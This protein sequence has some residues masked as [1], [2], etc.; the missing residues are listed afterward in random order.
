L[1]RSPDFSAD[2]RAQMQAA[3][4]SGADSMPSRAQTGTPESADAAGVSAEPSLLPRDVVL[5]LG[6]VYGDVIVTATLQ[7][8][9]GTDEN[10]ATVA[11]PLRRQAAHDEEAR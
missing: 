7:G 10:N 3:G 11:E 2:K 8:Y 4:R 9:D 5:P 6:A 1:Y